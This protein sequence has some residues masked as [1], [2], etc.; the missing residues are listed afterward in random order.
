MKHYE[1]IETEEGTSL[2]ATQGETIFWI[3]LDPANR[4]YAEYLAYTAW[5]EDG[6]DP[7]E[8]WTQSAL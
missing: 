1:S 8:F 7:N 5:V 3:P 4:D 2:K 6:K